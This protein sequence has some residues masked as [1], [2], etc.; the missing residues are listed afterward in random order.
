MLDLK[1]K[2]MYNEIYTMAIYIKKG[3]MKMTKLNKSLLVTIGIV[4]ALFIPTFIA[5]GN[6]VYSQ[7]ASVSESSITKLEI[8][9]P[10]GTL[11]TLSSDNSK[12]AADIA[13]FV[14]IN[15]NA[16]KKTSLP[17]ALAG[18]D[19]FEFKYY[20][21]DRVKTYNY[22]FSEN[23][24][25]AY[26]VDDRGTVYK[27]DE[28]DAKSFL[29]TEYARCLY[30]TSSFPALTVSDEKL[31]PVSG[32]WVYKTYSGDY[33][34]LNDIQQSQKTEQVYEMKGAF[35][36][37]FDNEP[38]FL[39]VTVSDDNGVVFSDSYA[40]IA[41]A[42]LAG[43]TIDVVV[44]AKW[45]ES[46]SES[47]YGSATYEFKAK[48]LLP[49]VFYLG[50][51]EI[52]PGEF[53]VI[54]AKN[55][56]DPSAITLATDPDI[57]F[58]PT[59]FT[60]GRY[61]RALVPVPM[62]YE[63]GDIKLICTYGEVSQEMTLNITP[64]TFRSSTFDV[65]ASTVSQ[66]RTETTLKAFND[67][68]APIVAQTESKPLW[69]GLFM[70]AVNSD[71]TVGFG[72][73]RI[74]SATGEVYRHQGVDYV[75][76]AGKEVMATNNGKVV[77]V[78]YLD[79]PGYMVVIDHGLGLKSWYCHLG[80][81]AV[82]VGDTVSKGDIVGYAGATGFTVKPFPHIG[83]SVYDVPVCPYDLWDEGILMTE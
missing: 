29:A 23:A 51:T 74:I 28:N 22:Y 57:G 3:E 46:E 54:S 49:A 9:D 48:I 1:A 59:F 75:A 69:E 77:Y 38:D 45:Y 56:D 25:E 72:I 43:R 40:N 70:E 58:T 83:L 21:Y 20:S 36:L 81:T 13:G 68:M 52:E 66:T 76:T 73:K 2:I 30:T 12:K 35:A 41:N 16:A 39:N 24:A 4:A 60:D 32:E 14:K 27:I 55:V 37:N 79:L 50:K 71:V 34:A 53:V 18:A 67:T 15:D 26:F 80:S 44:E 33:V 42:D 31:V 64:K 61:A 11:F 65:G 8:T 17:E 5:L 19:S 62:E 63:G 47:C 82:A 6:F 78:G 10:A 7:V